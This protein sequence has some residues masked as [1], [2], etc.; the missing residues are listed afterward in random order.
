[1]AVQA[2]GLLSRPL[3]YDERPC[4]K[5]PA[6]RWTHV[7]FTYDPAYRT[8]RTWVDFGIDREGFNPWHELADEIV[9]DGGDLVLFWN[10]PGVKVAQIHIA[11]KAL[12]I[13]RTPPAR[14]FVTENAYREAGYVR[15]APVS[16]AFPVPCEVAVRNNGNEARYKMTSRA[17]ANFPIPSAGVLNEQTELLVRVLVEGREFCRHETVVLNPSVKDVNVWRR[18]R[19]D[20]E[21]PDGHPEWWLNDDNTF[22]WKGEP[23]FPLG[24]YHVRTNAFDLVCDLGFNI[25]DLVRDTSTNAVPAWNREHEKFFA[26]AVERGVMLNPR[27]CVAGREGQSLMICFDEPWGYT[28]EPMRQAFMDLRDARTRAAELP[29]TGAMNNLMRFREMGMVTD[30]MSLDPYCRGGTPFRYIYDATRMAVRE[31]DG[32]KPVFPVLA[33]YGSARYRPDFDELRTASYLAIIGG[34]NGLCYYAWDDSDAPG[35]PQDTTTM[36]DQIE[37][38]RRLFAEF[39]ALNAVL[40]VPNM[41]DGPVV[42]DDEPRGVFVCAKREREKA[43]R[44]YVFVASDLYRTATRTLRFPLMAGRTATLV[45]GPGRSGTR[46]ENLVFDA[47][48]TATVTLPPLSTLVFSDGAPSVSSH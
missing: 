48:G 9:N 2:E 35:G 46:S 41:K 47:T 20:R 32:L 29:L 27:S 17:P 31:T 18:L 45:Y 34:A 23:F 19:G 44:V 42:A 37:N 1:M 33:N 26:K 12:E 8:L 5:F 22:S 7:A 28:F 38:F 6:Q 4:V 36:P 3:Q 39:K 25:L 10:S 11:G 15:L 40:T 24:L 14:F 16:D 13:G 21:A 30:V 43:G